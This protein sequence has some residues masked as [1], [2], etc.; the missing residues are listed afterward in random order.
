MSSVNMKVTSEIVK[1]AIIHPTLP[2]SHIVETYVFP[3]E[4][5]TTRGNTITLPF[6][7]KRM[8]RNPFFIVS[9]ITGFPFYPQITVEANRY[10]FF[11]ERAYYRQ[12]GYLYWRGEGQP[13][14]GSLEII[15]GEVSG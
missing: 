15:I 5:L 7:P 6:V 2:M 1:G 8:Y 14:I 3:P 4:Q 13:L 10:V 12:E 9:V 11:A